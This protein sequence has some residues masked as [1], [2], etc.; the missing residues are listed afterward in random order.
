VATSSRSRSKGRALVTKR[1]R[2]APVE[3]STLAGYHP[4]KGGVGEEGAW[5]RDSEGNLLAI[6]QPLR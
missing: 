3:I 5:F 6:G 2:A 4:S 1:V